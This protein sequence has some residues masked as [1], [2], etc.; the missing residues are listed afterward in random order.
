M[1]WLRP[2]L[3]AAVGA[4]LALGQAPAPAPPQLTAG[5]VLVAT[6]KVAPGRFLHAVVLLLNYSDKGAAGLVLNQPGREPLSR[7]FPQVESARQRTD[8][9][10]DG[11]PVDPQ[12]RFCLLH[13]NGP[14]REARVLLPGV[15]FS[16]SQ[17]LMELALN[18]QQPPAAFRV[19]Q[20]YAGWTPGQLERELAAGL[21]TVHPG[22]A[23]LIFDPSP[24]TLWDRLSRPAATPAAHSMQ[25][26]AASPAA[27]R[28]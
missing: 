25:T 2:I 1:T 21:W 18:A 10:F 19:F 16:T 12:T 28:R 6:G 4:A 14:L 20:G 8:T 26:P 27:A 22:S 11:G 13:L 3:V 17:P 5:Q 7:L 15:Y 9:A 24:S 23:A